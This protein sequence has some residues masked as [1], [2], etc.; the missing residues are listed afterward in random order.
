MPRA[1][2]STSPGPVR[3]RPADARPVPERLL[4]AA[5]ELVQAEGLPGLSQARVA[6]AAGV[7]QSHLTYYFP[8]RKDL[9]EAVVQAIRAGMIDALGA[10]APRGGHPA[11]ALSQV[12]E[13]FAARARDP[14]LCRLM[15][16]LMNAADEDPSLRRWLGEFDD[17]MVGLLRRVLARAGLRPRRDE[18]ALLHASL[19]GAAILGTQ[20][21][22]RASGDRSAR[23]VRLAFD[24]MA[25]APAPVPARS[26]APAPRARLAR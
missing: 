3:R 12:R 20:K 15:L 23:L 13:F 25:A 17:D 4:A 8:T 7:R 2:P 11:T 21:G 24:R 6:A 26:R 18:L 9:L 22:E 1:I 16:A 19:V 14:L 5:L 10:S